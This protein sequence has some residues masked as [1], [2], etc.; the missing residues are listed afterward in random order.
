MC[1]LYD[2]DK[3]SSGALTR[4]P[5]I[6]WIVIIIITKRLYRNALC[7]HMFSPVSINTRW[8]LPHSG[9]YIM[10]QICY[11]VDKQD[12]NMMCFI[13]LLFK[14]KGGVQVSFLIWW[15]RP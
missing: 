4:V 13:L 2:K 10:E 14:N 9:L 11:V 3:S 12:A 1:L 7:I 15:E 8:I 5:L 6:G